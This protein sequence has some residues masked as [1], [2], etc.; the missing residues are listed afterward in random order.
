MFPDYW[1]G[2]GPRGDAATRSLQQSFAGETRDLIV[3]ADVVAY[4]R[5]FFGNNALTGVPLENG[6]GQGSAGS[7]WEKSFFPMEHMNPAVENPGYLTTLSLTLMKWSGWYTTVNTSFAMP[8]YWGQGNTNM[9]STICPS[10]SEYCLNAN[11]ASCQQDY[12]SKAVCGD[13]STFMGTC[14]YR[15]NDGK[16]C[17]K[18]NASDYTQTMDSMETYGKN[19]RCFMVGGNPKCL[20]ATCDAGGTTIT[21]ST[22]SGTTYTNTTCTS[23]NQGQSSGGVNCPASVADF[24]TKLAASSCPN[25]C[26]G[27]GVCLIGGTCFCIDGYTGNDCSNNVGGPITTVIPPLPPANPSAASILQFLSLLALVLSQLLFK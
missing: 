5:T 18:G 17:V 6:G 7:H 4:A 21:V 1:N 20:N 19:S 22:R 15:K 13:F 12:L 8:Y 25:D 14:M 26:S 27:F 9:F 10:S 3:A 2:S 16:Y 11:Q 24:C 23:A